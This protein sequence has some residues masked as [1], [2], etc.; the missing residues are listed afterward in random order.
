M[1]GSELLMM[2]NQWSM[3][4][5]VAGGCMLMLGELAGEPRVVHVDAVYEAT[6]N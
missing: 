1:I 4:N 3:V 5:Q 2:I 6:T